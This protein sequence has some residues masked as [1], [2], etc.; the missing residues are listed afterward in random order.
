MLRSLGFIFLGRSRVRQL[1]L[2]ATVHNDG[3]VV[4]TKMTWC[5]LAPFH[6]SASTM[7]LLWEEEGDPILAVDGSRDV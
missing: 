6:A 1:G 3:A 7:S 5:L 2:T 4:P